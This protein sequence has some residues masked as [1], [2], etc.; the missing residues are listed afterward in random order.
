[1][2][3]PASGA[4][5]AVTEIVPP[6]ALGPVNATELCNMLRVRRRPRQVENAG[7]NERPLYRLVAVLCV[8]AGVFV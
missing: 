1:M 3:G 5:G 4:G 6:S 2:Q 7:E 8:I